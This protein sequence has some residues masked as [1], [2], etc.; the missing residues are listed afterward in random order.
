M[1]VA[2]VTAAVMMTAWGRVPWTDPWLAV[3]TITVAF[4]PRAIGAPL[5][6]ILP[7]S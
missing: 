7:G 2:F 1:S 4:V 5:G 3:S 6:D